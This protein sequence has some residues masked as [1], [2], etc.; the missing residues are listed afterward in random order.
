MSEIVF[1]VHQEE[2]GGYWTRAENIALHTQGDT[3]KELCDN[4]LEVVQL[5][6]DTIGE[7]K[8]LKVRLHLVH[9]QE[10]Q[11]VA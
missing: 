10:L 5:Y 9:D 4:V 2:D 11:L 1:N 3:W 8:P 7:P 6:F